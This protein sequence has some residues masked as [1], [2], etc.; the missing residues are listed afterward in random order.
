[1]KHQGG[2]K[3]KPIIYQD[4]MSTI[5]MI[6]K[7]GGSTRTR[8]MKIRQAYAKEQV[9]EGELEVEYM[10]TGQ[11]IADI[12]TKPLAGALF[13][14]LGTRLTNTLHTSEGV[15]SAIPLS[16]ERGEVM[17]DVRG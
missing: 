1:M 4:N 10:P 15:R 8:H 3:E 16:E 13:L 14:N 12:L 2:S 9:D 17:I 11:M 5:A 6:T 7:G